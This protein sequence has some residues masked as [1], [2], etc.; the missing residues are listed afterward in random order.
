MSSACYGSP[1]HLTETEIKLSKLS[2]TEIIVHWNLDYVV[3]HYLQKP[4]KVSAQQLKW[5]H[6]CFIISQ[7]VSKGI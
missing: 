6:S 7:T 2:S 1:C 3:Q 4:G 5:N